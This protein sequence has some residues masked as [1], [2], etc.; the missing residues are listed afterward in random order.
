MQAL[1]APICRRQERHLH[2]GPVRHAGAPVIVARQP[3]GK[4]VGRE[5]APGRAQLFF[6]QRHRTGHP[7]AVHP[8][9][10]APGA[11]PVL[12]RDNLPGKP[13]VRKSAVDAAM[14]A[15]ITVVV[16]CA[17]PDANGSEVRRLQCRGL[18]LIHGVIGDAIE[19]HFA[20][21][22]GLLGRP[23]DAV[24]LI[25]RLTQRPQVEQARRAARATRVHSHDR[26]S[27]RH[28]FLRIHHFPVLILVGGTRGHV[29][30][31]FAHPAPLGI[32][33]VLEMQPL[34]VRAVGQ[35]DRIPSVLDR[36]VDVGA[37]D[38]AIVHPDRHVPVDSHAVAD[39]AQL[40][41][42]HAASFLNAVTCDP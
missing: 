42:V 24:I 22:P 35:D 1:A 36:P 31:F 41:I 34:A 32:V 30:V 8:A 27:V 15:E 9:A 10:I 17:L 40:S 20:I 23:L 26:V 39:L 13:G 29:R 21:G 5:L 3:V 7:I 4:A 2:L 38:Q 6:R 16:G 19:P 28:P 18:P 33:Q 12:H 37:Q 25:L 14:M 11:P